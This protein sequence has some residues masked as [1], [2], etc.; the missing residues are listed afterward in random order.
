MLFLIVSII[1]LIILIFV[2]IKHKKKV[3]TLFTVIILLSVIIGVIANIP[4]HHNDVS[5]SEREILEKYI[6]NN[7]GLELTII[8]S[9]VIHRGNIGDNPGREYYFVMKNNMGFEYRLNIDSLS[10]N[11]DINSILKESPKLDIQQM[12]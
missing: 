2:F 8:E 9:T 7:Y 5:K 1:I 6:Q 10:D 12:K 3:F 4:Y 11:G